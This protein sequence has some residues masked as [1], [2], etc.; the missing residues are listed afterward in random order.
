[1]IDN[2]KSL[3]DDRKKQEM[4]DV[5]TDYSDFIIVFL[6]LPVLMQIIL[7][8]LMLMGFSLTHV[9]SVVLGLRK[10]G[11]GL[12]KNATVGEQLTV[13]SI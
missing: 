1:M 2:G 8:L 6:L 4:E 3:L 10:D 11:V 9:V 7:P 5:M 12:K 13:G